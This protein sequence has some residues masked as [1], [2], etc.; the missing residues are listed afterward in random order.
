MH[1][2]KLGCHYRRCVFFLLLLLFFCVYYC[3]VMSVWS[4]QDVS[5]LFF[6]WADF[7][8]FV[9]LLWAASIVE[10]MAFLVACHLTNKYACLLACLLR[11]YNRHKRRFTVSKNWTLLHFKQVY[12]RRYE[13]RRSPK[14]NYTSKTKITFYGTPVSAPLP[15]FYETC[16]R[17]QNSTEIKQWAAYCWDMAKNDFQNGGRPPSCISQMFVFGQLAIMEFQIYCSVL[18][19]IKIG[20]LFVEIWRL[21]DLRYGGRRP[22]WICE[23]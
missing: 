5:F 8:L 6:V 11:W 2:H 9:L 16:F 13:R 10:P 21:N 22:L 15:K 4:G 14:P 18:N 23:I 17:R 12:L 1:C 20:W 7:L 19:F 3:N